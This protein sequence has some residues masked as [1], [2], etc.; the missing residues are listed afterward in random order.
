MSKLAEMFIETGIVDLDTRQLFE[1][2]GLLASLESFREWR[3]RKFSTKEER[4]EFVNEVQKVLDK[5]V[6]AY[7]EVD[8]SSKG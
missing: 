8:F 5:E 1:K 7:K 3:D 4:Q 2:W 6:G